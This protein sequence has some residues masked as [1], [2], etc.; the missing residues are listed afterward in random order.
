[1]TAT[2]KKNN[3][4]LISVVMGENTI[5]MRTADTLAMLDYGFNM[6]NLDTVVSNEKPL[7]RIKIN[8]GDVEYVDIISKDNINILNNT[9]K[10]K[11][12][13]TYDIETEEIV[14]PIKI[15][16]IVGKINV[17]EDGR[18]SYNVELTVTNEVKRAN[19]LKIFIR[20]IRDIF[21]INL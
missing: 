21:S 12:N 11:K 1:L 10:G 2:G 4:R 20:N 8:L 9:Q 15:G 14:A 16:D 19:I 5:D 6:Y 17:Y 7:G 3:M 18:Y 13:I